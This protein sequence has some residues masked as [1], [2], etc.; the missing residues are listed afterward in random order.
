MSS[1]PPLETVLAAV[2]AIRARQPLVPSRPDCRPHPVALEA[3]AA[4]AAVNPNHS[5]V[6]SRTATGGLWDE[7]RELENEFIAF[8]RDLQ[9]A[10]LPVEGYVASGGS[11]GNAYGLY[12][13]RSWAAAAFNAEPGYVVG[14]NAHHSVWKALSL[15]ATPRSSVL[16]ADVDHEGR[17]D[18][19]R[20]EPALASFVE[21]GG[22]RY[23]VVVATAGT[24]AAGMV[25]DS[26]LLKELAVG[27]VGD[28][29]RAWLHVDAALGGLLAPGTD[30]FPKYAGVWDSLVIDWHKFGQCPYGVAVALARSDAIATVGQKADYVAGGL[31]FALAGSRSGALAA[32]G[33]AVATT[34]GLEGLTALAEQTRGI[35]RAFYDRAQE[36][37]PPFARASHGDLAQV[38]Q[39]TIDARAEVN[40]TG[41]FPGSWKD[42][43]GATIVPLY[44]PPHVTMDDAQKHCE[45]MFTLIGGRHAP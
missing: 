7:T 23:L 5:G 26:A 1:T 38:V 37:C 19:R 31:D 9:G 18:P 35:A 25:D 41:E 4:V 29:E 20:L 2:D 8:N 14:R 42:G 40:V 10:G 21:Q 27:A 17:I 30:Q 15:L 6:L 43:T 24:T 22:F 11:E 39:V 44:F 33:W 34:Y 12:C 28:P 32:A 36:L 16:V 13:A 3:L 45:R